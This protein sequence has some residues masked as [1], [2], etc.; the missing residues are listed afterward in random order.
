MVV[1]IAG[2]GLL[3]GSLALK[4]KEGQGNRILTLGRNLTR[5]E[6]AHDAGLIDAYSTDPEEIVPQADMI[7]IGT[8]VGTIP[9]IGESIQPFLKKN[10]LITDMGS[11]KE[12]ICKNMERILRRDDVSFVG[13]HPMAGSEKTGFEHSRPD[14]F[15]GA[16]VVITPTESSSEE[17]VLRISAMW[18]ETGALIRTMT[19]EHHDKLV[20]RTSHLPHAVAFAMAYALSKSEDAEA[21]FQGIYGRGLLDTLR[22]AASDP[23]MWED[24]IRTNRLNIADALEDYRGHLDVLENWIRQ[25]RYEEIVALMKTAGELRK[26]L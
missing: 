25:G 2:L 18:R 12:W 26:R 10:A 22:I 13:S 11:T 16:T 20:A 21:N 3:G 17:A 8:P 15:S 14:L 6:Q 19:P 1:L 9:M 7:V 4:L 24:I 5:L 23:V